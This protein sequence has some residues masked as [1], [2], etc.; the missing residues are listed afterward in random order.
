[1]K[2]TYSSLRAKDKLVEAYTSLQS[3]ILGIHHLVISN[4]T[5]RIKMSKTNKTQTHTQTSA[6]DRF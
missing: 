3:V 5:I 4:V 6:A 1:M 2:Q